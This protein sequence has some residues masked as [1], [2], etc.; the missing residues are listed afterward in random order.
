[1][2]KNLIKLVQGGLLLRLSDGV[3]RN[4]LIL[5]KRTR[6][7]NCVDITNIQKRTPFNATSL[8]FHVRLQIS[9][10]SMQ[11]RKFN[12]LTRIHV[13][14]RGYD[15]VVRTSMAKGMAKLGKRACTSAS[16]ASDASLSAV[17]T[18]RMVC[19]SRKLEIICYHGYEGERKGLSWLVSDGH[20]VAY[21]QIQQCIVIIGK[22]HYTQP[23]AHFSTFPALLAHF[24]RASRRTKSCLVRLANWTISIFLEKNTQNKQSTRKK[25][26]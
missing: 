11:G 13:G 8:F 21:Y 24:T 18:N 4:D 22:S 2:S 17:S 26:W 6:K 1:M 7:K 25:R 9:S 23:T 19:W 5:H 12:T 10:L 20:K 16:L 15:P 3:G 14:K